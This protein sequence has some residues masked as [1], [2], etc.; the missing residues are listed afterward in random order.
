MKNP[1]DST[2]PHKACNR[3][4]TSLGVLWSLLFLA[5]LVVNLHFLDYA[6]YGTTHY[7]LSQIII[8]LLFLTTSALIVSAL[9]WII[10]SPLNKYLIAIALSCMLITHF[11]NYFYK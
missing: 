3:L 6:H 8:A 2:A 7:A 5:T 11:Y 10:L 9:Y 4:V 1:K